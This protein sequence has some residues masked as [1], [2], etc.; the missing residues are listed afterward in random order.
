M[1]FTLT[2]DPN[3]TEATVTVTAAVIDDDVRAIEQIASGS[4]RGEL[5]RIIGTHG[6]DATVIDVR[7]VLAFYAKD[8]AV[9][10]HT[11]S[12]DYQLKQRLYEIDEAL[13]AADFVRISQS[14]IVNIGAIKNLDLSLTGTISVRLVDGTRYY[15]S[16]RQLPSFKTKLGL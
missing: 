9:W 4:T 10:A 16:R 5:R 3:A 7:T 12:G 6:S 2:I 14:E 1:K 13:P 11:T 15:V 8:K